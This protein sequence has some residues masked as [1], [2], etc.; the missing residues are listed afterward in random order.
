MWGKIL[1]ILDGISIDSKLNKDFD[2]KRMKA[3]MEH[4]MKNFH[5]KNDEHPALKWKPNPK[6][7]YRLNQI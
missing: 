2:F 7:K 6:L 5:L 4:D 1:E 3:E